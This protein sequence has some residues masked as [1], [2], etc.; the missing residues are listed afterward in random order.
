MHSLFFTA[1]VTLVWVSSLLNGTGLGGQYNTNVITI[2]ALWIF[3]L[4]GGKRS[5][6]QSRLLPQCG[7]Y[8]GRHQY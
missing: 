8:Q 5:V 4:A 6:F 2:A 7:R 3:A 1:G